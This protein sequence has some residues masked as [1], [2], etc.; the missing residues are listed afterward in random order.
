MFSAQT[1]PLL[2][3]ACSAQAQPVAFTLL[4]GHQF[5]T[6]N[7]FA[8]ERRGLAPYEQEHTLTLDLNGELPEVELPPG[9][10]LRAVDPSDRLGVWDRIERCGR[11][12]EPVL[13]RVGALTDDP[14]IEQRIA[15][16]LDE[17]GW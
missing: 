14:E 17:Y 8:L 9:L 1:L 10:S 12:L 2:G 7:D 16:W 6:G 4:A 15:D 3:R 11:F 5:G 13:R